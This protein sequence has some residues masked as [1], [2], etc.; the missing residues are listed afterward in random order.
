[1]LRHT[2]TSV[3]VNVRLHVQSEEGPINVRKTG[4][5]MRV[6]ENMLVTIKDNLLVSNY[7]KGNVSGYILTC[8]GQFSQQTLVL[9]SHVFCQLKTIKSVLNNYYFTFMFV[10]RKL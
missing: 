9:S 10:H 6:S 8:F 4:L 7:C 5:I 3:S 2:L 1:M